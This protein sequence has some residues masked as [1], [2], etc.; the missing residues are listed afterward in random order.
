MKI[1][2]PFLALENMKVR[3]NAMLYCV[4]I[5]EKKSGRTVKTVLETEDHFKAWTIV[6]EYNKEYGVGAKYL[7]EYPKESYFVDVFNDEAR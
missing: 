5:R 6:D 7:S 3:N 1:I 2:Q 4:D